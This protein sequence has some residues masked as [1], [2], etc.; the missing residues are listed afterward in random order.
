[1]RKVKAALQNAKALFVNSNM[2]VK[3]LYMKSEFVDLD[4]AVIFLLFN[5]QNDHIIAKIRAN[6][7][8]NGVSCVSA[9]QRAAHRGF[10]GN[11]AFEHIRPH[12]GHQLIGHLLIAHTGDLDSHPVIKTNFILAGAVGDDFGGGDHALQIADAALAFVQ[13]LLGRLVFKIF[14][15]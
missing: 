13:L 5:G 11:A 12:G 7:N 10:P 9:G 3:K 1:M 4:A 15:Q 2:Q 14:A 8:M 6:L